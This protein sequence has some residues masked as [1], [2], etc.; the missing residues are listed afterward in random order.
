MAPSEELWQVVHS[1]TLECI[2]IPYGSPNILSLVS[3]QFSLQTPLRSI[4]CLQE[5]RELET[6]LPGGALVWAGAG[7]PG[8]C[9]VYLDGSPLSSSCSGV[10]FPCQV[11]N[12]NRKGVTEAPRS[13]LALFVWQ[14]SEP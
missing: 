11:C 14:D 4:T 6:T 2:P 13:R 1:E 7:C 9:L 5:S 12:I 10:T 3:N 8:R